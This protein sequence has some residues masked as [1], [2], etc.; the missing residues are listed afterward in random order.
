MT[1][2]FISSR[3][4]C[5]LDCK[6]CFF[7]SHVDLKNTVVFYCI[8][9]TVT[10][11]FFLMVQN[12]N[13]RSYVGIVLGFFPAVWRKLLKSSDEKKILS[14]FE[15]IRLSLGSLGVCVDKNW[16]VYCLSSI[17]FQFGHDFR[18]LVCFI[19]DYFMFSLSAHD[20]W[21]VSSKFST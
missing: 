20:I 7:Q 12:S 1:Q 11:L 16:I 4:S 19:W 8:T 9:L 10:W 6:Y 3:H 14:S 5:S 21:L 2:M 13:S 15:L 18:M 17:L